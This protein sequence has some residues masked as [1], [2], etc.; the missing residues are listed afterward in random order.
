MRHTAIVVWS[1]LI[2][3]C[4]A[5]PSAAVAQER[6]GFWGGVGGGYGSAGVSCDECEGDRESSGIGYLRGGWTLN[7]RTLIGAELNVWTKTAPVEQNVDMTVNLYNMSGTLTFYPKVS[8]GF[9][10]K[11]GV[12]VAFLDAEVAERGTRLSIDLGKGVGVMTG[13]GYDF[14]VG[15]SVSLTPG[16]NFWYGQPGDLKFAG[17]TIFENWKQNVVDFTIGIT[18]H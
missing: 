7:P 15:R 17:D 11:G 4:L 16:F 5:L 18:F 1:I 6:A 8:S 9:F 13:V 3:W 12:G 2:M 10:V 14:R